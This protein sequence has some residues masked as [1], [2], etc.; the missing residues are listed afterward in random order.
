MKR[1]LLVAVII[2]LTLIC[3]AEIEK[4]DY[5]ITELSPN[6]YKLSI[7]GG[8]YDVKVLAFTGEDGLLLVETGLKE[9][10]ENLKKTLK[11]IYDQEPVYIINSHEHTEHTGGNYIF[12][13]NAIIIGHENLRK[14][15]TSGV[16]LFSEIP[17]ELI[18]EL[19]FSQPITLH[20]NN[21]EIKL[22][23][24]IGSHTNNDI[25]VWFSK[26]KVAYVG[27][28]SNGKHFPSVDE[29]GSTLK[30]KD[31]VQKLLDLLPDEVQ[32]IPGHG[33]DGTM[34]DLHT[35]H[36]MLINTESMVRRAMAAG[37]DLETM[38]KEDLLKGYESYESYTDKALWI[39]YLQEAIAGLPEQKE[40]IYETLY[41]TMKAKG[42]EAA[43]DQYHELKQNEPDRFDFAELDLFMIGYKLSDAGKHRASIRFFEQHAV[44]YPKSEYI[45]LSNYNIGSSYEELQDVENARKNYEKSL[46]N[47]P[48]NPY[49]KKALEEISSK[50]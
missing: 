5:Q 35:F 32:I 10:A 8:G 23:P 30:Y 34:A 29:T 33:A 14:T 22:I 13:Q 7:D 15:L 40:K 46:E 20:F 31:N 3:F 16:N 42:V 38:Q 17:P 9:K 28:I 41:W 1:F 49:A 47:N 2:F 25:L 27:A 36:K 18:P 11:T 48:D 19:T 44:E 45:W 26:A 50:E 39:N 24:V 37:K 12:S 21:E 43:L 4:T 6:L